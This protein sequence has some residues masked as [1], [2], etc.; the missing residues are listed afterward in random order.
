MSHTA[1][2]LFLF[3]ADS[4]CMYV[5]NGKYWVTPDTRRGQVQLVWSNGDLK[6]E[7]MDRRD[8]TVVDS[9]KV[10]RGGKFERILDDD[11]VY[12]W[13]AGPKKWE[14]YWMQDLEKEGED[15]LLVQV[16]QY[17]MNP[18]EA[19]P[20]GAAAAAPDVTNNNAQVDALSNILE[21]LG[22][23]E[24]AEVPVPAR[25]TAGTLTLADLQGA[26]AGLQTAPAA[27]APLSEVLTPAAITS[28]LQDEAAKNRLLELLPEE[29]RSMEYLEDNLRSPQIQ[30]TLRALSSALAPDDT[31]SLEGYHSVIANFQ[32]DPRDGEAA[33]AAG[34]PIQAFL[35]CILASVEKEEETKEETK[36]DAMEE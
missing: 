28:L 10:G 6:W 14:M 7:W 2:F 34:N 4:P 9:V 36:D 16:N 1:S 23:P 33:L 25:S 12:L 5:Q 17:L 13:T 32:L 19:A 27:P 26:M 31:G 8:K 35:D 24:G 22:M 30:Q 3:S 20:G 29:Q 21:N 11:R 18:D 15:D